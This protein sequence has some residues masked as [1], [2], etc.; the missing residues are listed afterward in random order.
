MSVMTSACLTHGL[1][2][3]KHS[4]VF[5]HI[6][7]QNILIPQLSPIQT[8]NRRKCRSPDTS[9]IETTLP[10]GIYIFVCSYPAVFSSSSLFLPFFRFTGVRCGSLQSGTST[11]GSSY[12]NL[13]FVL[14]PRL[15]HSRTLMGGWWDKQSCKDY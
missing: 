12:A 2:T 3:K 8:R 9:S 1:K 4:N 6:L 7:C 10:L 5:N 11:V 15:I 13:H 14:L